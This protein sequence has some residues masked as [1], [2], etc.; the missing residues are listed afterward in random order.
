MNKNLRIWPISQAI[1][2]IFYLQAVISFLTIMH[3]YLLYLHAHVMKVSTWSALGCN[4][5]KYTATTAPYACTMLFELPIKNCLQPVSLQ[6]KPAGSSCLWCNWATQGKNKQQLWSL[7]SSYLL[8]LINQPKHD[9]NK[10]HLP[11]FRW[12]QLQIKWV[13]LQTCLGSCPVPVKTKEKSHG[14]RTVS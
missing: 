10:Q 7:G 9:D 2:F 8:Q 11:V 4:E 5:Q 12:K 6:V 3:I 13:H 1:H 14:G